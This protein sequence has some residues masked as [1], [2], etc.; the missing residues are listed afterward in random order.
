METQA[1][2]IKTLDLEGQFL[3]CFYELVFT[4]YK[5]LKLL[6]LTIPDIPQDPLF[7]KRL[8]ENG[9]ISN[10]V[11]IG[12]ECDHVIGCPPWFIKI[13]QNVHRACITS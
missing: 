12:T 10:L 2:S 9:T 13:I 7:Y 8:G 6:R 4:K 1:K 5:N 11:L 3:D